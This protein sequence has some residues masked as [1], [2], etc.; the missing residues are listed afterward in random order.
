CQWTPRDAQ[1]LAGDG[2]NWETVLHTAR[3]YTCVPT[4]ASL[5]TGRWVHQLGT[6]CSAEPYEGQSPS[7]GHRL[8]DTGHR[9]ASIGKLHFRDSHERNGFTEE[10][11]PMHIV[12]GN[13]W[14]KGL[15][16]QHPLPSYERET[17]EFAE[18]VGP[19]E[20]SYTHYD[21]HI[22]KAAC[23]WLQDRADRPGDKPWTLFVSLVC[24]H[25]PLYAPQQFFDMY[26]PNTVDLPYAADPSEWPQ[27]PVMKEF[28]EFYN[29]DQFFDESRIR[30]A[31]A[32]Y[33]ALCSFLDDNVG[34]ILTALDE[35]GLTDET[36]IIYTSDH[37]EILGN[38]GQWTKMCMYED[39]VSIPFIMSGPDIPA[40]KVVDTP[41]SLVDSY[42][43]IIECV[44]EPLTEAEI[45]EMPGQ[46]LFDIIKREPKDRVMFSEYHDGGTTV[47]FFMIRSGPWKYIYYPGFAPQLFNLVEDPQELI[48]SGE[49]PD[50][51]EIRANCEAELRNI[52]DPE[53][54]NARAHADQAARLAEMG[55]ADAILNLPNSDFGFTPP[56]H[57]GIDFGEL[58]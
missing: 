10:I 50:Y 1:C 6:W 11:L 5:A 58:P 34:Q 30:L 2:P 51:A 57:V 43:T 45:T 33:Y 9:V 13:G 7:W 46:S 55:G 35:T 31:I 53:A 37:G 12:N 23:D 52:V 36:R 25:F 42:Q 15:I 29:Y 40:G 41:V 56:K 39:S 8:R 38:H 4:R 26:D 3:H 32:S 18:Q 21:R 47:G 14:V 54:A 28:Y 24:P 27:H 16:R 19:G 48:D 17:R 20:S 49:H 22:T 44:G